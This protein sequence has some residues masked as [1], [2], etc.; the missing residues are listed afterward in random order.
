MTQRER[1]ERLLKER[2]PLG[3]TQA[4][5]DGPTVDGGLPIRRL[6]ARVE[7]LRRAGWTIKS[8]KDPSKFSRYV[9]VSAVVKQAVVTGASSRLTSAPT[10][11]LV[12]HVQP[13]SESLFEVAANPYENEL[14]W[15]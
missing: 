10:G 3:I 9:L 6:A 7:E 4:D 5:F 12:N 13:A 8:L 1:V 11:R 15:V 2:G 14:E